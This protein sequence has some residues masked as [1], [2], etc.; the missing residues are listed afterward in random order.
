MNIT[1]NDEKCQSILCMC[2]DFYSLKMYTAGAQLKMASAQI[3]T[4]HL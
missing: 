1:V 3:F 2:C 4:L